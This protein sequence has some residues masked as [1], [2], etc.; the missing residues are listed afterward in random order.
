MKQ[1]LEHVMDLDIV[2]GSSRAI[3]LSLKSPGCVLYIQC[4]RAREPNL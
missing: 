3:S 1:T 4:S 2:A